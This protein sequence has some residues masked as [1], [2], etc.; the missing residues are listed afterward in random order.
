LNLK[1]NAR[2]DVYVR[3]SPIMEAAVG[4][5]IKAELLGWIEHVKP[6]FHA[7]I[8]LPSISPKPG[9]YFG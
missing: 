1:F 8:I 6:R 2:P 4:Q 9:E 5:V 7:E 3:E